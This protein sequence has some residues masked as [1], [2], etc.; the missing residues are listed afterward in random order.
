MV[1]RR[2]NNP[3]GHGL[4]GHGLSGACA[5]HPDHAGTV[6]RHG[7][8]G[9]VQQFHIENQ[10]RFGGNSGMSRIGA[11]A[12]P[13]AI[14]QLPGNEQTTLAAH[15]HSFKALAEARNQ[16]SSALRKAEGLR[17]SL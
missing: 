1:Q 13:R 9:H 4:S 2:G 15:L 8:F 17:H 7:R 11:R 5:R 10:V 16:A 12:P 14:G 6:L 3:A